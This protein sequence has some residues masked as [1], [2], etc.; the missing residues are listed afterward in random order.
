[1]NGDEHHRRREGQ[2]CVL[3]DDI[4]DTAGTLCAGRRRR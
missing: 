1:V 4:V 3:V 2:D